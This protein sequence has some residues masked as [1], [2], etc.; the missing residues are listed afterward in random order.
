MVIRLDHLTGD[1]IKK[2]IPDLAALRIKIFRDYPYLYDGNLKSEDAL[3]KF[4]A[5]STG[6]YIMVLL[7]DARV[8]GA[9]TVI[10]MEDNP[11]ELGSALSTNGYQ[12]TDFIYFGELLL[13][14]PYRG[15]GFGHAFFNNGEEYGRKIGRRYSA[16]CTVVRPENH[17]LKPKNYRSLD[18]FWHQRGYVPIDGA[19]ASASWREV[20]AASEALNS[21]QFWMR[22]L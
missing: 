20:G 9:A 1:A 13:L 2:A 7:D 21:L 22:R 15:Q 4:Y 10:P 8:I 11:E 16:L 5:E 3:L 6:A 12:L 19:I 18:T 14:P 17:P